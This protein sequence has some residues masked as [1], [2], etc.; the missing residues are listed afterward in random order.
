MCVC[1]ENEID[2]IVRHESFGWGLTKWKIENCFMALTI[3]RFSLASENAVWV[4]QGGELF[5][6]KLK[7]G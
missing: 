3:F 5:V 7:R 6:A 1:V 4:R 2:S